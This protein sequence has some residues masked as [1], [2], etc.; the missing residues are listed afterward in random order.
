VNGTRPLSI[1]ST[2][3]SCY[4]LDVNQNQYPVRVVTQSTWNLRG[5][6]NTNSNF[7]DVLFYD[8]QFP[9]GILNFDPEPNLGVT[10]YFDSYLQLSE[11]NSL[12]ALLILPPGYKLAIRS[13]LTIALHAWFPNGTID[14][15]VVQEA[16][17]SK[18]NIKRTNIRPDVASYDPEIVSRARGRYSVYTDSSR[19]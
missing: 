11:F 2:E 19:R 8:P 7:P 10:A 3:G 15:A 13:N 12:D 4:I 5:S 1:I 14:P 17:E 18:A 16:A 9:L 6:R